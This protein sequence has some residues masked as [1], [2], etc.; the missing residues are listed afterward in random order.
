MLKERDLWLKAR[1]NGIGA[2]DASSILGMN[3]YKSNVEL[4]EEKTNRRI[5]EDIS[6]K[7]YVKYGND[8][9][10]LLRDLFIL[11][12]PQYEVNYNE[13]EMMAKVKGYPFIFATLD[14]GLKEKLA[15]RLGV[16]EIKT[17]EIQQSNQWEKWKDQVPTNY[18]VQLLHQLLATGYDFAVL[19]AQIKWYK[20]SEMQLTTKHYFIE[21]VEVQADINYL[22]QEEIKFWENVKKDNRPNLILPNI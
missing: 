20:Q 19:K 7:S 21:R 8:A 3:P 13:F 6:S 2:S 9:E 11:D 22:L 14:G 15:G 17:T 4:W 16:L 10:H 5:A 1:I 12:Y 18:Y